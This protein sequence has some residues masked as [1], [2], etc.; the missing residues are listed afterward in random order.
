MLSLIALALW[1]CGGNDLSDEERVFQGRCSGLS[2]YLAAA[3]Q[4]GMIDWPLS[5]IE[6]MDRRFSQS[7]HGSPAAWSWRALDLWR[8]G[9]AEGEKLGSEFARGGAS[10]TVQNLARD[11][12]AFAQA[13]HRP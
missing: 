6:D 3:A 11:C 5:A 9:F 7:P 1:G 4:R 12:I 13:R 2:P 8:E 10:A